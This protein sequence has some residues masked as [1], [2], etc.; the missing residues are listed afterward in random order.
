MSSSKTVAANRVHHLSLNQ[1]SKKNPKH[2]PGRASATV[3]NSSEV[4]ANELSIF[5]H[6]HK[7]K[8]ESG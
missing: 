7:G 4:V 1:E 6:E 2:L 5:S 8:R 3:S